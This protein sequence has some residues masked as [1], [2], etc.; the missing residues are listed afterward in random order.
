MESNSIDV[1]VPQ[2]KL[3]ASIAAKVRANAGPASHKFATFLQLARE[4][5]PKAERIKAVKALER[6]LG[7]QMVV[8]GRKYGK[9]G[10]LAVRELLLTTAVESTTLTQTA[11]WGTVLEGA[12][13]ATCFRNAIWNM[14]PMPAKKVTIP[15]GEAHSYAD[16]VGE[17]ATVPEYHM[18]YGSVDLEAKKYGTRPA[19]TEEMLEDSLYDVAAMEVRNSGARIENTANQQMLTTLLDGALQEH[20]SGG[21]NQGIKSVAAAKSLVKA[22]GFIPD[23]LVVCGGAEAKINED[24]IPSS[25]VGAAEVMAGRIP[26]MLGLRVFNCD[27]VD[28]SATYTWEYNSDGDIGMLVYDSQ[29]AGCLGW[30]RDIRVEKFKDVLADVTHAVITARLGTVTVEGNACARVEY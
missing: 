21:S 30:R 7:Y 16:E 28:A 26:P 18:D 10:P 9:K 19:I 5:A 8:D 12:Q 14:N 4:E 15:K 17:G 13:P 24:F 25:Y 6:K 27:V 23:T 3:A 20:D 1:M 29:K 22:Q 2:H 11:M